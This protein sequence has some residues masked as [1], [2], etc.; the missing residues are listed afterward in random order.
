M[1]VYSE[2]MLAGKAVKSQRGMGVRK[3]AMQCIAASPLYTRTH[4]LCAL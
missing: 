2:R 3:L 4:G 1:N